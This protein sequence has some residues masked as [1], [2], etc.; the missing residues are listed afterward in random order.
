MIEYIDGLLMENIIDANKKGE[1]IPQGKRPARGKVPELLL[2][3]EGREG[4]VEKMQEIL[5]FGCKLVHL[6]LIIKIIKM[7]YKA[8]CSTMQVQYL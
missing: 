5:Y 2:G 1:G 3:Y 8:T 4:P 6:Q 7:L